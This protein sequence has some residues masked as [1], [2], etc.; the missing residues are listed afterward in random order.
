MA[1][2]TI[3]MLMGMRR[4][5]REQVSTSRGSTADIRGTSTTSSKVRAS[6]PTLSLHR[7]VSAAR[8]APS[9]IFSAQ[10]TGW[11]TIGSPAFH[12]WNHR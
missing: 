1:A 2:L 8:A 11:L 3:G 12:M 6:G 5:K 4:E 7:T 9:W 10:A